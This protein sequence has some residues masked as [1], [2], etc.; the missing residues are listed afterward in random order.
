[1]FLPVNILVN[2]EI[3]SYFV[4]VKRPIISYA[5]FMNSFDDHSVSVKIVPHYPIVKFNFEKHPSFPENLDLIRT[6]P[7]FWDSDLM[8]EFRMVESPF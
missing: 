2:F 8:L 7:A 6:F 3:N 5:S 1:M 4:I